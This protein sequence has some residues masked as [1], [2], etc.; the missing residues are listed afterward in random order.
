MF[1]ISS[2][3]DGEKTIIDETVNSIK[4]YHPDE[5]IVICDADS[6][7]KDYADHLIC[8]TVEFFD[9]KNQ[10]RPF[11]ALMETYKKYPN[12]SHYVLMHDTSALLSSIQKFIDLDTGLVSFV[13]CP[14]P[15]Q[16]IPPEIKSRYFEWM[17][18]TFPKIGYNLG[19]NIKVDETY[20]VCVG[21]MGVYKNWLLKKFFDQGFYENF[22]AYDFDEAQFVERSIGYIAKL[23]GI[24]LVENSIEGNSY[25][26]WYDL[27]T[28]NLK[29]FKKIFGGR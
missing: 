26:V 23:E 27:P 25:D 6:P 2:Y 20:S 29:Y 1:V 11:G 9:A 10:R 12:E 17:K 5:K 13:Q 19:S 18:E 8:D 15:I 14:R 22:N 16:S 3:Y 28:G 7:R 4:K 24:D 21:C